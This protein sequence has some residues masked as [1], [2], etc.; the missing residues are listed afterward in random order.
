MSLSLTGTRSGLGVSPL[1]KSVAEQLA[2]AYGV[3][4]ALL[5]IDDLVIDRFA[6]RR[7]VV[8]RKNSLAV[9]V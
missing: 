3:Y 8:Y 5:L 6:Q 2:R 7:G 1:E 9:Q 4:A